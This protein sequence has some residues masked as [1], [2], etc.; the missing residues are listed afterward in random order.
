VLCGSWAVTYLVFPWSDERVTDLLIYAADARA[1]L[2][3]G[4]PYRDVFFEYPPLAAPVLALPGIAGTGYETYR[5]AFGLLMLAFAACV[6][7]LVR[8]LARATGGHERLAMAAVALAPLAT[9]ALIRNH[10]DLVPVALTLAALVLMLRAR[11]V[12]GLAVLGAA[13]AVKGYPLV[14]APVALAWLLARGERRAALRGGAALALVATGA[15]ALAVAISPAGAVDALRWQTDRPV[16]V[17]SAAGVAART[18][19]GEHVHSHRADGV[20]G[21]AAA[22]LAAVIGLAGAAVVALLAVGAARRP[23]PRD[24]V[25]GSLAAVTAFAAFG[26]VLSPQYVVWTLPLLALALAWRLHALAA[27]LAAA[28]LLTFA[29][30]PSRYADVVDGDGAA[31]A[32]VAARDVLLLVAVGL[33]ARALLSAPEPAR[34]S[35]RST[36]RGRPG[37]P[38]SA[39]RSATPGR[40]PS[41]T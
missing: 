19:G 21:G 38:R 2:G 15:A 4:L 22:P 34:V 18:L 35:A 26:K 20:S 17:E 32:L 27:A 10:F 29:E 14:V 31:I 1:F 5:V 6:L 8:A 23:G 41:R 9:G 12:G 36:A 3:G 7:L 37:P 33:A 25:L 16:Q 24:L 40:R 11:P 13:V 30:F 39:L 28:A